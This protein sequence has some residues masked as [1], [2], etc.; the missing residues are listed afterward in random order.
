M[1]IIINSY[2][3]RQGI[4]I[5]LIDSLQ[6]RLR[7]LRRIKNSYLPR[8]GIIFIIIN[9]H[10]QLFPSIIFYMLYIIFSLMAVT[11]AV[12]LAGGLGTRMRHLT[13]DEIPKALV[14]VNGRT[15]TEI[16]IDNLK[17]MGITDVFLSIGHHAGQIK[18]YF[19]NGSGFGVRI[20]YLVEEEPLGT[21]G[22]MNLADKS[23]LN[24]TFLVC[25]GDD[26]LE[27]GNEGLERFHT[28]HRENNAA[29]SIA[30]TETE[31]V[32]E[33]GVAELEGSRIKKFVEKPSPDNAPSNLISTG[34]YLFEP[35]VLSLLQAKKVISLEK[36]LF[37]M[38]AAAG[39]LYGFSL[40]AKWYSIGTK[41]EYEKARGRE[42][43]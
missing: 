27:L 10:H 43:C 4:I 38:I 13:N 26:I 35:E 19:G 20:H 12:V 5:I 15:I 23:E 42:G 34:N 29:V 9:K 22:W 17:S 25:N 40:D 31:N 8:P 37:P 3:A 28:L 24:E 16:V 7:I 14:K 33:K 36:D 39:G 2:L 1:L 41:E 21:G 18:E 30:L 6:A 32:S 11:K